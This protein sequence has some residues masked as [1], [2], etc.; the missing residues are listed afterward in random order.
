[1]GGRVQTVAQLVAEL[2]QQGM[3]FSSEG[4]ALRY[5]GPQSLIETPAF[6]QLRKRKGEAV[7]L[8]DLQLALRSLTPLTPSKHS[9]VAPL[10]AIQSAWWALAVEGQELDHQVAVE[11][12]LSAP[13][14]MESVSRALES[15]VQRHQ[16]F[17]TV[18]RVESGQIRQIVLPGSAVDFDWIDLDGAQ[19]GSAPTPSFWD[20]GEDFRR[21]RISLETGPALIGRLVTGQG[22]PIL[23][24]SFSRLAVDYPSQ[25]LLIR[26]ILWLLQAGR[27]TEARLPELTIQYADYAIWE[28]ENLQRDAFGRDDRRWASRL[29]TVPKTSF[30]QNRTPGPWRRAELN[31]PFNASVMASLAVA[32]EKLGADRAAILL[33]AVNSLAAAWCGQSKIAMSLFAHERPK[34]CEQLIGCFAQLR[35]LRFDVADDPKFLEAV[36]RT[37]EALLEACNPRY[38][39]SAADIAGHNLHRLILNLTRAPAASAFEMVASASSLRVSERADF[40]YEIAVSLT[41]YPRAIIG[42]LDFAF[43]AVDESRARWFVQ[44]I[45]ALILSGCGAPEARLSQLLA[46]I[47]QDDALATEKVG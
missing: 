7:R 38:T 4:G 14:E 46:E 40:F 24:L 9:H 12:P 21:R 43:E 2:E 3:R 31:I 16:A 27:T 30:V 10:S 25:A 17:R 36:Q 13:V 8:I 19:E 29:A 11:I 45:P 22:S 26:E 32:E 44:A 39:V 42:K 23:L 18:Y 15:L 6:D 1:M 34:G 35:P 5:R 41:L 33:A 28:E 37:S 20:V 47:G